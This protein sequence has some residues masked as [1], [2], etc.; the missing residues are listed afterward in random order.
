MTTQS[1]DEV[2]DIETPVPTPVPEEP[3]QEL[4]PMS[5]PPPTPRPVESPPKVSIILSIKE[6][7]RPWFGI[8]EKTQKILI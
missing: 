6:K 4:L 3:P 1:L 5:P 8:T 2:H 7:G